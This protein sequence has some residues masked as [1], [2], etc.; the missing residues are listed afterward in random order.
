MRG[1][2]KIR[3]QGRL[4][5]PGR[6]GKEGSDRQKQRHSKEDSADQAEER[7]EK[8]VKKAEADGGG[9]VAKDL[10]EQRGGDH[11]GG[12]DEKE[13]GELGEWLRG[14]QPSE[15]RTRLAI[16]PAGEEKAAEHAAEGE[17]FRD[18]AAHGRAHDGV[19]EDDAE[20]P[21]EWGHGADK[22]NA[23]HRR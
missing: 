8:T 19:D 20:D 13:G 6:G 23:Y 10:G 4:L 15:S 7:A 16:E 12:K 2:K 1:A 3:R 11:G 18:E 9:G 17:G 5:Q 22:I 14:D 21:V